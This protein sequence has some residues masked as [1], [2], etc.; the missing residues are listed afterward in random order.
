MCHKKEI[1]MHEGAIVHSLFEIAKE[2]KEKEKIIEIIE[3]KIIVGKFHQIVEEVMMMHFDLM[4]AEYKG[5]ENA[6]LKMKE[7]D[8]KIKCKNCGQESI[9]NEP[10]FF[11]SNC[12]SFDTELISGK[13]LHIETIEGM[14]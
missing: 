4:K 12:E 13:E 11:C 14:R 6:V 10:I 5:F 9:L 2:I 3:L 8:V 1:I 7:I